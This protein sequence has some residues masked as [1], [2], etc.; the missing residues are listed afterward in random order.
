MKNNIGNKLDLRSNLRVFT[1][2]SILLFSITGCGIHKASFDCSG[3]KGMGCGSM[4]GVHKAIK[5]KEFPKESENDQL[6]QNQV[7]NTN[8]L[9]SISDSTDRINDDG[10]QIYRSQDKI[11]RVWFNSYFD[12]QNNFHESKYVYTVISPSQWVVAR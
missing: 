5:N 11:M 10:H 6:S 8:I 3:S 7:K 12:N 4:I 1:G 2:I 9:N